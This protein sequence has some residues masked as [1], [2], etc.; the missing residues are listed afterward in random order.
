MIQ[1]EAPYAFLYSLLG[2][3]PLALED[4]WEGEASWHERNQIWL[5]IWL[6]PSATNRRKS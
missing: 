6:L 5:V 2:S 3:F 1:S 4:P